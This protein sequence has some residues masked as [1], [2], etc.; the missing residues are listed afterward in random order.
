MTA[1]RAEGRL[2]DEMY[3]TQFAFEEAKHTQVFRLWLDA[4]GVTEDLQV[5]LD[6]LPTYRTIFYEELP[7]SLDALATDP[8]PAAQVRASVTYNH[9]IEGMMALTGY[10]AWQ[11]ICVDNNILPGMQELVRRIGD[12]ERRH[13]AWGTFTCRRHVA[14]DDSNWAVFEHR[15][16]EL[17]PLALQNT[18]DAYDLYDEIPF[19]LQKEEFQ[20]YAAD[21]GMRRFGTISSAR[22]RP[23]AEIDVDYSPLH[24][25][26]AFADEDRKALAASA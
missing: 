25:E 9:V 8:S 19:N 18:D 16:N 6:D 14:A 26:D 10:H 17:I 21:K 15:M 11:R 5:L 7:A 2:G 22:G 13:M 24:L 1:M 3:L 12:D 23:L 20:T 4:V